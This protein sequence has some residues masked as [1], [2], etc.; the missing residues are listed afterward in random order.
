MKRKKTSFK[1]SK[2][3][4]KIEADRQTPL[5]NKT[6]VKINTQMAHYFKINQIMH[7]IKFQVKVRVRM[8]TDCRTS[9]TMRIWMHLAS[10]TATQS[11]LKKPNNCKGMQELV[12][13]QI[14]HFWEDRQ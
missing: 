14:N 8:Q 10:A 3:S 6:R 5:I 11:I 4:W 9:L 2:I 12:A 1:D 7:S 13:E